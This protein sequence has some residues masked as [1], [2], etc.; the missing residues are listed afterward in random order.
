MFCQEKMWKYLYF[1][2][3]LN[4]FIL[5]LFAHDMFTAL[6]DMEALLVNELHTADIIENYVREEI[7][8]LE[9]LKE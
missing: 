8:R 7:K 5:F 2:I 3:F 1:I 6:P 4:Y 9:R